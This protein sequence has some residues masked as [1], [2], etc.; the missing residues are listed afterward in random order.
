MIEFRLDGGARSAITPGPQSA[1]PHVPV[2]KAPV[3]TPVL[4]LLL[5]TSLLFGSRSLARD[6]QTAPL[7]PD[8]VKAEVKQIGIGKEVKVRLTGG[9][10]V[11]G[12]L[13][14]IGDDS[15]SV[16]TGKHG[17]ERQIRYDQVA[18]V[19]DP[20][21]LTWI[22]VGAAIAVIIIVIVH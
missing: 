12:H 5:S 10:R 8:A 21:P 11:R 13:A 20:G 19:K 16:R 3:S 9:E 17:S 15:F 22:L 1:T 2:H 6:R 14:S 18:D 4:L 7:S